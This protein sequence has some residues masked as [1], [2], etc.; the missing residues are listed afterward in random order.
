V[1][2]E[3]LCTIETMVYLTHPSGYMPSTLS[4][5]GVNRVSDMLISF[6]IPDVGQCPEVLEFRV[7]PRANYTDRETAASRRR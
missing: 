5:E 7:S 1:K 4:L 2:M 3:A 6:T